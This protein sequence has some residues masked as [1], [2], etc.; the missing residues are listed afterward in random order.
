VG[1][2]R[3]AGKWGLVDMGGF[4]VRLAGVIVAPDVDA[5]GVKTAMTG[6]EIEDGGRLEG[7]LGEKFECAFFMDAVE[8]VAQCVIVEAVGVDRGAEEE[9]GVL[10]G[11]E[12]LHLVE[13]ATT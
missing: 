10:L 3:R 9:F 1:P 6:I 5:G 2:D 7:Y 12:F 4:L 11:D 8:C 13:W